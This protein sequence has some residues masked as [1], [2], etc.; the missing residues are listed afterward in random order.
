MIAFVVACV[1]ASSLTL[2]SE[3]RGDADSSGVVRICRGLQGQQIFYSRQWLRLK[4]YASDR[5]GFDQPTI[6]CTGVCGV[7]ISLRDGFQLSAFFPTPRA[8]VGEEWSNRDGLISA[9]VLEK[10]KKRILYLGDVP[11]WIPK[12]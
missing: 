2:A 9:V 6:I 7:S 1:V 12:K 4:P 3:S 5:H 8:H 11:S 10:K